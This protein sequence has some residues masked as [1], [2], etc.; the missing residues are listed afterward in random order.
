MEKQTGDIE[1]FRAVGLRPATP[2]DQEFL[3]NL[4]ASTRTHEL[5]LMNCDEK[6]K[7]AFIAMQFKAQSQQYVM[8]YPLAQNSIILWNEDPVGRLLLD[9]GELELTLV[10]VA[11]LPTHRGTGIGTCLVQNIVKEAAVAGKPIRLHVLSSNP[12]RRLYER[13]GFSR[14]GGDAAYLEMMWVPLV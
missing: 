5:A 9:R 1:A 7:E 6:Q 13:L 3:R 11:L 10:D 8:N 12:A 2:A 4:F 14:T